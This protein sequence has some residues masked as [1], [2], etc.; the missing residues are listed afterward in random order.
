LVAEQADCAGNPANAGSE[1]TA[2][3]DS[4]DPIERVLRTG[5]AE[6][7]AEKRWA[8]VAALGNALQAHREARANVVDLTAVRRSKTR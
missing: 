8:D 2:Q 4:I 3:D 6:A 7:T 1:T 5:L